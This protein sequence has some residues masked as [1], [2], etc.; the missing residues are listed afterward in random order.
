MIKYTSGPWCVINSEERKKIFGDEDTNC[1]GLTI[2][3]NDYD[4]DPSIIAEVP[5]WVPGEGNSDA[6]LI[7]A[8]PDLLEALEE[9]A[10]FE[11]DNFA[12]HVSVIDKARAAIA[13]AKGK[14]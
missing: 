1:S 3:T 8:A 7:A 6:N 10:R 12:Q 11:F 9:L 4:D 2:I 13:K 14:A 5:E